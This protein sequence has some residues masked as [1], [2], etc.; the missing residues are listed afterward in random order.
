MSLA[1]ISGQMLWKCITQNDHCDYALI[2]D[3]DRDSNHHHVSTHSRLTKMIVI[4][5]AENT[6]LFK[7][8]MK[9]CDRRNLRDLNNANFTIRL[10]FI[11]AMVLQKNIFFG[12]RMQL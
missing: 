2:K 11:R 4:K 9:N 7:N 10:N 6:A 3:N 12:A 1:C 8:V 5:V